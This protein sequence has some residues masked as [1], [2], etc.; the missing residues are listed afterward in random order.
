VKPPKVIENINTIQAAGLI[1]W[2]QLHTGNSNINYQVTTKQGDWAIRINQ[3]NPGVDRQL[4]AQILQL[5]TPLNIAPKII[6]NN[7]HE[8]YLITEYIKADMW[9]SSDF[10]Q[11]KYINTLNECLDQF[12]QLTFIHPKSRLDQRLKHYL[13]KLPG[14]PTKLKTELLSAIEQLDHLGFWHACNT[15]YH[16]DL[17]PSNILGHQ[18]ITLLDWEFA[19]QGHPLLDWLIMEQESQV[20]LSDYYPCSGL[21]EK[22]IAPAKLMIQSMMKLWSFHTV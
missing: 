1:S 22:W 19:G 2:Q 17:N 20:D 8:G 18:H 16:S 21:N 3:P 13:K 10:E 15:L 9:L 4:E 14:I 5:I 11:A 12:H 6:E 7:P